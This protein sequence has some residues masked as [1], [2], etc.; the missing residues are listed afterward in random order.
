MDEEF[1]VP[2]AKVV[3][4]VFAIRTFDKPVFGTFAMAHLQYFTSQAKVG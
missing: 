3:E 4:A 2:F 1:F